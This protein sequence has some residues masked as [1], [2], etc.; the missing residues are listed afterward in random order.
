MDQPTIGE[1]AAR[2]RV[3]ML[4]LM[5]AVAVA[6]VAIGWVAGY[7][8]SR[9][10]GWGTVGL[11]W[12]GR[13]RAFAGGAVP[14]LGSLSLFVLAIA[15]ADRD[16]PP[17]R[18]LVERPGMA[19]CLAC[20]IQSGWSAYFTACYFVLKP[21]VNLGLPVHEPIPTPLSWFTVSMLDTG[22]IVA[23]VW[24]F[25]GVAFGW[26][27]HPGALDRVGRALGLAWIALFL[28]IYCLEAMY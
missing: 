24:I 9:P 10:Q 20:L 16:R 15:V 17:M 22:A 23:A 3:T 21:H 18:K 7:R 1:R 6:A 25:L 2:R 14:W 26:R 8:E 12:W 13:V 5:V 28:V 27:G 19:A 4:D 11:S